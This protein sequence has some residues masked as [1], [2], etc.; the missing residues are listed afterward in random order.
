MTEEPLYRIGMGYDV[1]ALKPGL[2]LMLGCVHFDNSNVGLEGHSDADVVAHAVCD[3][4]LGAAGLG[5]IGDNFP[6]TDP[7]Y[8][9]YPGAGFLER[10]AAMLR[11]EGLE[12]ENVDCVVSSDAVRL[13]GRKKQMAK[14][15]ATAL[16]LAANRVS[17]K[18]TTHEGF[19]AVGRGEVVA[20]SA[21]AL[22]KKVE[23]R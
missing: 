11:D 17:V 8:K 22:V 9:N 3:A 18:A 15:I 14:S 21:V 1:H 10:V 6:D 20:C 4:L 2:K 23:T 5:D 13:G 12:I 19:G 7:A 16:N